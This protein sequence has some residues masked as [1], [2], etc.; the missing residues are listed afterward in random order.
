MDRYECA[1]VVVVDVVVR[2][3][4]RTDAIVACFPSHVPADEITKSRAATLQRNQ[5]RIHRRRRTRPSHECSVLAQYFRAEDVKRAETTCQI[6]QFSQPGSKR[7]ARY[8]HV[9]RR[10]LRQASRITLT[11]QA[12]T[13]GIG[14]AREQGLL[15]HRADARPHLNGLFLFVCGLCT[16]PCHV[17]N[18]QWVMRVIQTHPCTACRIA[19]REK[20]SWPPVRKHSRD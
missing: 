6:A 4:R 8:L 2:H 12:S 3:P 10:A 19:E 7:K 11:K 15:T 14:Y 16:W 1:V 5:V 18:A 17:G 20:I 9:S 13:M